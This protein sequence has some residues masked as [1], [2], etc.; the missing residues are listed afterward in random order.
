MSTQNQT[1]KFVVITVLLITTQI[2]VA[3][4]QQKDSSKVVID[5]TKVESETTRRYA[6]DGV[7]V[8]EKI[9]RDRKDGLVGLVS[10]PGQVFDPKYKG[11]V[12][13]KV[14]KLNEESEA[15]L[16]LRKRAIELGLKRTVMEPKN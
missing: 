4:A 2:I 3:N 6:I 12:M 14:S 9:F 10:Y 16:K 15:V 1:I 7:L 11:M 8:T 5:T 13:M